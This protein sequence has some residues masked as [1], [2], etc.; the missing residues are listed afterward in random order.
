[1]PL[2]NIYHPP[3][4]FTSTKSALA[5][6]ITEIYTGV[7]LPAFYVNVYFQ[8]IEPESCYI[9]GVARPSPKNEEDGPGPDSETP[10]IRITI[11]N[12][13]RTLFVPPIS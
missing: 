9:G 7:G 5:K 10:F 2:W 6:A 3:S 4:T 11:Q 1:M 13:A 12:I 8:P